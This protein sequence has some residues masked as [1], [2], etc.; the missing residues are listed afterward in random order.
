MFYNKKSTRRKVI[1]AGMTTLAALT[2][3]S[4]DIFASKKAPGEVRVIFLVGDYWHNPITQEKNWRHVLGPAGWRLMFAQGA[5]FITPEVLAQADLLVVSRYAKTNS[6]GYAPDRIV[7][8]RPDEV[9]LLTDEREKAI[10]KNVNRGM[11]LL[12]MH[13]AIWNGERKNFMELLGVEKPYMH[14]KVQPAYLHNLNQNHPITKGIE[15]SNLGEDEIFYADLKADRTTPLF[16]LKGEEQPIDRT[17][18]WCLDVGKGRVVAL[19]PGHN[20]HPFHQKTFKEIMWRSAH[21]AMNKDIPQADLQN[22]RP[23][24]RSIY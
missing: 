13:C 17:G 12:A 2:G 16:N 18:G 9:T 15:P 22:G 24:E 23:P 14:T 5:Q 19:L 10:I 4:K 7:E 21:W 20:P 6:L 1:K 11:G 8:G 3:Y